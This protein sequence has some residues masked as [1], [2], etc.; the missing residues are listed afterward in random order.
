MF[1]TLIW[2]IYFWGYMLFKWPLLHKGLKLLEQGDWEASDALADQYVPDWAGKVMKMAGVTLETHGLENIPKDRACVFAANHRS[3][4]DIPVV[5][6]QLDKPH[7]LVAKQEIQHIPLVRGWMKLLHCVFLDRDD[8]RKAMRALNEATENLKKGYSVSIFPEGTRNK[9]EEGTLLEF[10]SGAFRMASKAKAP[11]VP[12]AITGTRDL[13]ENHHM[14]MTPG[15]VV[16]RI[17]PPI[18][19]AN[20]SREE[21]KNLPELV[22]EEIRKKLGP[23]LE[24]GISAK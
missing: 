9:G 4:Y 1:R 19:T 22:R 17:L 11:V 7:A 20:M 14:L 18:E 5:L 12:V 21:L 6:T 3:Y 23:N 15:H 16:V 2:Y 24:Q 10:K 8:P 13:M